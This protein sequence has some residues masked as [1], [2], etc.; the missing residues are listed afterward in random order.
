MVDETRFVTSAALPAPRRCSASILPSFI[1]A[2]TGSIHR[3]KLAAAMQ[4]RVHTGPEAVVALTAMLQSQ[5]MGD[6][7]RD[8]LALNFGLHYGGRDLADQLKD[9]LRQLRGFLLSHKVSLHVG[10]W[11]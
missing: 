9:D 5:D 1:A 6:L 4:V 10:V 2:Q 8:L 7:P 3:R 11:I